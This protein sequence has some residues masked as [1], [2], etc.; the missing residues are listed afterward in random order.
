M[1][2]VSASGFLGGVKEYMFRGIQQLP[3]VLAATSLLFT[4]TTGS[5][6]HAN[7]AIGLIFLMPLFTW[8]SHLFYGF[9]FN[10][11]YPG[12][13][14]WTRATGNSC[15]IIQS[16]EKRMNSYFNTK[17][18]AE[19][20]PSYWLM[21]LSFFIGYAVSNAVD[22]LTSPSDPNADP[23]HLEKR[24]SQAIYCIVATSV[25]SVILL[26]VRFRMMRG[27]EGRG[28]LGLVFS[29]L[30]ATVAAVIGWGIYNVSRSC[31]S[32]ASDLFGVLSQIIPASSSSPHPIVCAESQ[33]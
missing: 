27:C 23:T 20:I 2:L 32:R 11:L 6:A 18:S 17:Q 31:G 7:L 10:I 12:D 15:N 25:L 33:D 1:S 22:S 9:V 21:S 3:I 29:I 26:G 30:S 14:S 4:I 5:I 28:W 8:I 19:P 16:V 13:I 24:N